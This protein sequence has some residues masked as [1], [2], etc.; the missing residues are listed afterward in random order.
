MNII[1]IGPPGAGKGTQAQALIERFSIPQVSTGDI[2]RAT[3]KE[4]SP[5]AEKLRTYTSSGQLVP[6][7]LVDEIV[8]QRLRQPDCAKGFLLDGYPRTLAQAK[9]LDAALVARSQ[10]LDHVIFVDVPDDVLIRR[11]AGR[12]SDP[13]TGRIYHMEFDPPPPD[14]AQRLVQRNDDTEEVFGRRLREYRD[15]TAPLIPYY[16]A[17]GLLRRVDGNGPMAEVGRRLEAILR[18]G[19][20]SGAIH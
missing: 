19:S 9:T 13:K 16:D 1:L 14:I 15:K 4:A 12:R 5:L 7:A 2:I 17:A 11:I 3:I 18:T 20:S 8:E 10:R 6:D